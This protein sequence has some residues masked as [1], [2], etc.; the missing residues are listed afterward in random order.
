ML[1]F[2]LTA[3][4]FFALS[5]IWAQNS[6]RTVT[7]TTEQG[8]S[9]NV[10]YCLLQDK[11]GFIWAGTHYGL[12][13][14]DGYT[15]KSF[16]KSSDNAASLPDNTI[17]DMV[18]EGAI[19]WLSTDAGI[20]RFSKKDHRS[21]L[22]TPRGSIAMK[23][24]YDMA[25]LNDSLVVV[26][27]YNMVGLLNTRRETLRIMDSPGTLGI[28][29]NRFFCLQ[30]GRMFFLSTDPREK[31][32]YYVN[33]KESRVEKT[34]EESLFPFIPEGRVGNYFA[35]QSGN[36]W[37]YYLNKGWATY[38]PDG[39]TS[40]FKLPMVTASSPTACFAQDGNRVWMGSD[41]GIIY[42][43]LVTGSSVLITNQDQQLLVNKVYSLLPDQQQNLWAGTF[44][45]GV[46]KVGFQQS[47]GHVGIFNNPEML[48]G[49][50]LTGMRKLPSGELLVFDFT[51]FELRDQQFR[52]IASGQNTLFDPRV[53]QKIIGNSTGELSRSLLDT[54]RLY[55]S[56]WV[57]ALRDSRNRIFAGTDMRDTEGKLL[58]R[59][60]APISQIE[61]DASGN[62]WVISLSGL[63]RVDSNDHVTRI[64]FKGFEGWANM[65]TLLH[66][67]NGK[68]WL[69]TT[70]G[71][72]LLEYPSLRFRRF[73]VN[74]GLPDN[75][76]Y[77]LQKDQAGN[78]WISTNKGLSCYQ[79]SLNRFVNFSRRHGLVNT[80]YNS[81]CS[82]KWDDSTMVFGG[83]S[84]LDF[85]DPAKMLKVA[86]RIPEVLITGWAVNG[87]DTG[88]LSHLSVGHRMNNWTISYTTNDMLYPQDIYFRYRL[89]GAPV[90]WVYTQGINKAIFSGLN[91]G[92]YLFEVQ[93]SY[94]GNKWS[95]PAVASFE[96]RRPFFQTWWFYVLIFSLISGIAVAVF[97]Y[98]LQQRIHM[99]NIRNRIS[100][101][102]HDEVGSSLSGIRIFSQMAEAKIDTEPEVTRTYLQKVQGYCESV[103]GS[104]SDIVWTINPEND[105]LEKVF[106]KLKGY[107]VS[108]AEPS[109]VRVEFL[110]ESSLSE[111]GLDMEARRNIYLIGKEAIHNAIR[112]SGCRKLRV[113]MHVTGEMLVLC[114]KD[115]GN[116]FDLQRPVA[117][118]GLRNMR[119][120]ASDI[121]AMLEVDAGPSGTSVRLTVRLT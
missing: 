70:E 8:L 27:Y 34:V 3:I 62:T 56:S 67:G 95:V 53:A 35:D 71:L 75:Y 113:S 60:S 41:Q 108:L 50:M 107:A 18:E 14:F 4:F 114:I 38:G 2:S 106:G 5:F 92:N 29:Y 85:I 88:Q 48:S 22:I 76:I 42:C 58:F 110:G 64:A 39:G 46:S 17:Y 81:R 59:N 19:L 1:R 51:Q 9:E 103:L 78:I 120:R 104:M 40:R 55:G 69:G 99:L 91:P 79:P 13:R 117:G 109:D 97:R 86:D 6:R 43:D 87:K 16:Y 26:S 90:G 82:V 37:V 101:D 74:D 57:F 24:T 77:Q 89:A 21:S 10:V 100:K 105:S 28:G 72:I 121:G 119:D 30:D 111:K 7:Y 11:D 112:H 32:I 52:K 73:D 83:T 25:R 102:L 47:P 63:Y 23:G 33:A 80:E 15:W 44:G 31:G 118:N 49:N 61:E 98:R 36:H 115:D 66:A 96:I 54:F 68:F 20:V 45:G 84:G 65:V 93:A 116:G 12:N 94:N